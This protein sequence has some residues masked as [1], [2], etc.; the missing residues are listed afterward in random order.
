MNIKIELPEI[1]AEEGETISLQSEIKDSIIA[2][3]KTKTAE[4]VMKEMGEAIKQ[5]VES[6]VKKL[7][8]EILPKLLDTEYQEVSAWGEKKEK[9]TLR[10]KVLQTMAKAFEYDISNRY[11]SDKNA[12]SQAVKYAVDELVKEAKIDI[13]KNIEKEFTA[14]CILEAKEEIKRTL[15][16][17]S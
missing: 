15:G 2:E 3:I 13:R 5:T 10:S 6:E 12:Y 7:I 11:S 9:Y 4:L 16:I 1:F 8:D 14:M 17:K